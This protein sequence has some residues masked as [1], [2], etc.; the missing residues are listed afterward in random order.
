MSIVNDLPETPVADPM[1]SG[2]LTSEFWVSLIPQALGLLIILGVILPADKSTL[3]N[4][5]TAV[6]GAVGTLAG[7]VLVIWKYIQSRTTLKQEQIKADAVVDVAQAKAQLPAQ[8]PG[9][10][11]VTNVTVETVPDVG[12][13]M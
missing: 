2:V 9:G 5:L 11:V 7:S 10:D 6:V 4:A 8:K 12:T 13:H 3:E 1:K